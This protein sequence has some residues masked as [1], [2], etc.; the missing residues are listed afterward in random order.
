[1]EYW[2]DGY[3]SSRCDDTQKGLENWSGRRWLTL[4]GWRESAC[5]TNVHCSKYVETPSESSPVVR[6]CIRTRKWAHQRIPHPLVP[7][8]LAKPESSIREWHPASVD[9]RDTG[10]IEWRFSFGCYFV[11]RL[12]EIGVHRGATGSAL[13]PAANILQKGR[14][15]GYL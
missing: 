8:F 12:L 2:W 7:C 9:V 14:T 10:S 6:Y 5:A 15:S 13:A 11:W 4:A 1:M 3:V